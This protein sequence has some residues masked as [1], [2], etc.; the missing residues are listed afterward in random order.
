MSIIYSLVAKDPEVV[1]SDYTSYEGN[2]QQICMQLLNKVEAYSKKTFET[3]EY[4][5]HYINEDGLTC[6]CMTNKS[7]NKKVAFA[8]LCDIKKTFLNYY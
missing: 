1:L 7:F 4:F 3:E 8:F 2:F 5:F 6:F